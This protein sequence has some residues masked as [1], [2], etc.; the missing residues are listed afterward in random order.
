M[1]TMAGKL[2]AEVLAG[3]AGRWD[4]MAALP[5]PRFPGGRRL[6]S[7]LLVAAMLWFSLRDRL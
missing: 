6:R 1:A 7:P 2:A 5:S 3:Q 4:A